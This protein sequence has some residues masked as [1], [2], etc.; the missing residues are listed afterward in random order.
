MKKIRKI[1]ALALAI[2]MLAGLMPTNVFAEDTRTPISNIVAK[3]DTDSIP[4]YGG[5]V[6]KPTFTVTQGSPAYFDKVMCSWRKKDGTSWVSYKGTAFTEGT[7]CY[8]VQIRI[9]GEAGKT[10]KLNEEGVTVTAVS[11]THL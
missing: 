2:F 10:H 9:D 6:K 4:V 3:S 1:L 7:Y 8:G 11:Y 5:T